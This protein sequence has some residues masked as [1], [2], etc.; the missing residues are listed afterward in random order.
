MKS[1]SENSRTMLNAPTSVSQQGQK[2]KRERKGQKKIFKE[3]IVENF[4]NMGK[5]PLTQ[6][7][8]VQ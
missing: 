8:E 3:I 1:I 4:P 6:S 7:Q 2:K 5:E